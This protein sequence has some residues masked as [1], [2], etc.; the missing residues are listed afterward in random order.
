MSS[1]TV[2]GRGLRP[3]GVHVL[4]S[5]YGRHWVP[6]FVEPFTARMPWL[7]PP[8]DHQLSLAG[9]WARAVPELVVPASLEA[10]DVAVLP[11]DL[12]GCRGDSA[13][14]GRAEHLAATARAA[15]KVVLAFCRGD[16][17]FPAP[18]PNCVVFRTSS[19]RK[20]LGRRDVMMPAWVADPLA[21]VELVTRPWTATPK[22]NF[23]GFAY[24]LGVDFGGRAAN[25]MKWPKAALRAL[26]T[27]VGFTDRFGRGPL[28]LHRVA[29]VAALQRARGVEA[30]VVL[31]QSM[32]YLDG[33]QARLE[34]MHRDYL[35]RISESDYTLAVRGE[36]NYSFRLYESLAAGRPVVSV[37]TDDV[38]PCSGDVPWDRIALDVPFRRLARIGSE[39]RRGHDERRSEWAELQLLCR[40]AWRESLSAAG[41]FRRLVRRVGAAAQRGP[42]VPEVIAAELA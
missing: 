29:A 11:F 23:V 18:G 5:E 28:Y 1:D 40:E 21:T 20:A 22:V 3:L 2:P 35:Q 37:R 27:A 34:E 14:F 17:E 31:R 8:T 42:L 41:Y 32:T 16:I 26:S 25:A 30:D 15:G 9:D 19:S 13:L 39:I 38:R 10:A 6:T 36:G 12:E 33:D 4:E 24:P 7:G